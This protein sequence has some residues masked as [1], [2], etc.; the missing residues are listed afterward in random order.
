[1]LTQR[2]GS[3]NQKKDAY[4]DN[5]I[6]IIV[7]NPGSCDDVWFSTDYGFPHLSVH[8]KTAQA[9]AVQ[10]KK[11][12]KIGVSVSLQISNTIGHGEY[13][14]KCDCSGLLYE[15]S[16]VEHMA[17]PDGN[18]AGHCFCW[19]GEHFIKYT[20]EM[21]KI[22]A[23]LMP[24]TVWFDDDLRPC[25]HAPVDRGCFC[26]NCIAEFNKIH[27]SNFTREQ[28]VWQVN[29]GDIVWRARYIEFIKQGLY[30]FAYKMCRTI[31]E[32][33]PDSV[34]G[35]QLASF[36]SYVGG[37]GEAFI[38]H[39]MKA[40]SG[41][42]PV[43][44]PGGGA[45]NDHDPVDFIH[46]ANRLCKQNR[47]LP[48]YVEEIR[49]EIENLPDVIYGK[50]IPGTCFETSYYF[51]T[52]STAM[53]YAM[54]MNTFEDFSW[55]GDMLK[56]FSEHRTY[57]KE[58][59]EI[60]KQTVQGGI[61]LAC[62]RD[63]WKMKCEQAFDYDEGEGNSEAVLRF[64]NLPISY[65]RDGGGVFILYGDNVKRFSDDE[66]ESLICKPVLTD[67]S[68]IAQLSARGF[69]FGA[70]AQHIDVVRLDEKFENHPINKRMEGLSWCG[71][72]P[73]YAGD[74]KLIDLDGTTECFGRYEGGTGLEE[75]HGE[76]ANAIVRTEKG[77]S[78]AV[79]G[80]DLWN[81]TVRTHKRDQIINAVEYISGTPMPAK[82]VTPIQAIV[83][84]RLYKN[85]ALACV[86]VT[87]CTIGNS[88]QLLLKVDHPAGA[89]G[90]F[91]AQYM[92]STEVFVDENGMVAIPNI[93]PWSV[94][95]VFFTPLS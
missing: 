39:A 62:A 4:I 53:S 5:V 55:H 84:P 56:S 87:N 13:M 21:V 79:Y 26:P 17:G 34:M 2:L 59:A 45:Y 14:A 31:H 29:F 36:G 58:L 15:D 54:L 38:Y 70:A 11:F 49:P 1:M 64:I 27:K 50:S 61:T 12:E 18:M 41:K 95:T 37:D 22:Y 71:S 91:M 68:T 40:A 52:G 80:F 92:P 32:I 6:K 63:A 72:F 8:E 78:W 33:S 46:K 77:A 73:A 60:N 42:N 35:L 74:W 83:L 24:H 93:A 76:M 25:N 3:E 82:L 85:G 7:Q 75:N 57:W 69:K 16:P 86:S 20:L 48:E 51:A 23:R 94:G 47:L 28:L 67:A 90:V 10:S 19:R 81:R 30:D 65:E 89:K 43:S 66:I 88:G 9:I 44:R